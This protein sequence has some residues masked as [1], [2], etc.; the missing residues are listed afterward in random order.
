M[1][2]ESVIATYAIESFHP[3]EY[4]AEVLAGEQSSG[5]F[6]AVPGESED[7]QHTYRARV[8]SVEEGARKEFPSLPGAQRP[9]GADGAQYVN[10]GTI[11]IEFPLHN[12]GPSIANMLAAVSGNLYELRELAAARLLDLDLPQGLT[13]RYKGPTFGIGG[14]RRAIGGSAECGIMIGTIIKPSIGLTPEDLRPIVRELVESG[15]DFIKDDE[16]IGNPPYSPLPERVRVVMEEVERGAQRTGKKTMYAFNITDDIELMREHYETVR[17]AGGTCVMVCVNLIGFPALAHLRSYS[18]LPIHGHRT[19]IGALMRYPGLGIDFLA[20]QKIV[21]LCG[22]DQLHVGGMN[23]KF[24]ESNDEIRASI[25]AV[26]A[27]MLGGYEILPV[28]SSGQ[29]AGTAQPTYEITKSTDFLFLA[30]GGIHA[31]R[32]GRAAGVTSLRQAWEA[33]LAGVPL[34][35]YAKSHTELAQA[36]ATFAKA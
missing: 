35:E 2:D 24:Y 15:I 7:L 3:L 18:E 22:A 14:T 31:H 13:E 25:E 8:L 30:G 6:V 23:N 10:S 16:L 4:A 1:A 5:T 9:P 26:R 28:L 36:I 21:R 29:W 19:M 12:F 34:E 20:Y 11:R 33:A 17:A 32:G 27:P